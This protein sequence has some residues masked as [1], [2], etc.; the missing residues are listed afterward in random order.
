VRAR[1]N[2]MSKGQQYSFICEEKIASK[3]ERVV[4]FADG[5][6]KSKEKKGQD[7]IFCVLKGD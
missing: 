2:K 6:V 7:T 5:T 1:L 4:T 3:I